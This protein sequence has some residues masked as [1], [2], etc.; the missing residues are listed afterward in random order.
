MGFAED[1]KKS[2]H[3]ITYIKSYRSCILIMVTFYLPEQVSMIIV[4]LKIAKILANVVP[5]YPFAPKRESFLESSL[6]SL[7]PAL[8]SYTI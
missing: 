2:S 8:L 4:I 1:H 3:Q 7:L 5:Y 6:A